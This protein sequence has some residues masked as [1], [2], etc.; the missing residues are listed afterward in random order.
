MQWC[1][2]TTLESSFEVHAGIYL[3]ALMNINLTFYKLYYTGDETCSDV[4]VCQFGYR[5]CS[6]GLLCTDDICNELTNSCENPVANYSK[7]SDP[8]ATDQ[9]IES[10][11]GCQFSCGA[12][13][14]TWMDIDG[15]LVLDL[16]SG[17]S[18]FATPPNTTERLGNLLEA[19]IFVGDRYGIRM[20]GWLAPPV[21]GSYRF[22][23]VADESGEFWLST[24]DD[25]A[26]MV[27]V[28]YQPYAAKR[29]D[30]FYYREQQ[31]E[32]I[33]LVGGQAYYFEVRACNVM[34]ILSRRSHSWLYFL[35]ERDSLRLCRPCILPS[36]L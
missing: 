15:F 35:T 18:N 29:N 32:P 12:T 4:G 3:F 14:E 27:L 20:K 25:P 30:W 7:S 34:R 33:A 10:L 1:V 28:C 11:G 19:Q 13:L 23:I 16:M 26:N 2:F 21:S 8:C 31:S 36:R 9:C 5:T 24:D 6:D 17:T 22:W